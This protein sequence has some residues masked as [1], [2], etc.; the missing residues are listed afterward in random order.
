[1]EPSDGPK[2][3][4]LRLYDAV[5]TGDL[6]AIE[7]LFSRR[8]GVLAIGSDPAEWWAGHDAIVR[9]FEAQI[10]EM[11]T[12]RIDPGELSAFVEGTVGWAVDRRTKR[13]PNGKELTVRETTVFHQEVGEWRIV[14]FHASLAVSN[15][16]AFS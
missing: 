12:R 3:A 2:N 11:G 16:E 8:S 7:R 6:S 9:A 13:L 10:G 5:A 14:Q 4:V 1:M 15:A